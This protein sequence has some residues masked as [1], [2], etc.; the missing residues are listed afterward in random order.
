MIRTQDDLDQALAALVAADPQLEPVARRAGPLPLR[1]MPTG[2]RGF[3]ATVIGQQVSRASAAAIFARFEREVDLDDP[4]SILRAD[5]LAFR[6]AGL[7]VA[8]HRTMLAIAEA[9]VGGRLDFHRISGSPA[10]AAVAEM[11][12]ARGI[13]RWTAESYLLFSLGH[14]DVFPAGDLAL[15]VA[16]AEALGHESRLR[17]KPLL[18]LSER[19]R[20]ARAV[21]A[22]LFW[23]YY[24]A[25][26]RR[27]AVI[28]APVQQGR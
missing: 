23:A 12:A 28:A 2:L 19:W 10:E 20:P 5:E 13:G 16:V 22:R 6:R 4:A 15:Q 7:S 9:I 17:E 26:T 14:R 24:A 21:A 27:D 25:L 8:K 11:T 3:A 18:A 1:A